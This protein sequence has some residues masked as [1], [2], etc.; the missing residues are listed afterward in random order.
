MEREAEIVS[1]CRKNRNQGIIIFVNK[2]QEGH[3]ISRILDMYNI[4]YERLGKGKYSS[5]QLNDFNSGF[6]HGV[7]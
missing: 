5:S 7:L 6:L 3:H 4:R 2:T 1:I